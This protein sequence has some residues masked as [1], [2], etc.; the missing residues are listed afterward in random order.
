[1]NVTSVVLGSG[2]PLGSEPELN[3]GFWLMSWM[4]LALK[5]SKNV[6][7]NFSLLPPALLSPTWVNSLIRV[8]S[9]ATRVPLRSRMAGPPLTPN[10]STLSRTW[11]CWALVC[12]MTNVSGTGMSTRAVPNGSA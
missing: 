12:W 1:M 11:M 9:G 8:P 3:G 4:W 5:S 10:I 2:L 6:F 7:W